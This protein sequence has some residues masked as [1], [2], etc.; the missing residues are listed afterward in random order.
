MFFSARES[1][2]LFFLRKKHRIQVSFRELSQKC[3]EFRK[4]RLNLK[5]WAH[6]S[7]LLL[8]YLTIN[9]NFDL[10]DFDI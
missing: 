10:L 4:L 5:K 7:K 1:V 6:I 9:L 3:A 2:N 8:D